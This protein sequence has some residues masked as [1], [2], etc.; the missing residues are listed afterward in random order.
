MSLPGQSAS[1]GKPPG[2]PS[3][4]AAIVAAARK[5][6]GDAYVYGATGPKAFDCSGLVQY[7]MHEVGITMPRT[8]E[9]QW[10]AV[11][12]ISK[13]QLQPG[14]LV[15]SQWPGDGAAPGHV[16]IYIG[17][18]KVLGADDPA[19]GVRVVPLSADAGHIVGYGRP[20]GAGVS[21]N[22]QGGQGGGG[23]LLSLALPADVLSLFSTGEQLASKLMWLVNPENWARIV[24]GFAGLFLAAFGLGFLV[25]SAV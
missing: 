9:A 15:F 18:G 2:G 19:V 14:D 17:G 8:S 21:A 10:G 16:E 3:L 4:G 20:P 1:T 5:L 6:L 22:V 12:K 25:W 24:A 11:T 13:A 7:V 23:G